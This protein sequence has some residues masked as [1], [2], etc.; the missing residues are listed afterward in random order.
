MTQ[1]VLGNNG[2][3]AAKL[4]VLE[5]SLPGANVQLF[6]TFNF[7]NVSARWAMMGCGSLWLTA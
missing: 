6:D 7:Y 2:L 1:L 5:A 3:Q 4:P